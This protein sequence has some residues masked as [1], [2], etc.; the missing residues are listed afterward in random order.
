MSRIVQQRHVRSRPPGL[1]DRPVGQTVATGASDADITVDFFDSC[2]PGIRIEGSVFPTVGGL[3]FFRGGAL[4]P[5][6]ACVPFALISN[7]RSACASP[8]QSSGQYRFRQGS[9]V[10]VLAVRAPRA[11]G[12]LLIFTRLHIRS[13]T[14]RP[15]GDPL[16]SSMSRVV[17][18]GREG[19][20]QRSGTLPT[21]ANL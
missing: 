18:R 3:A 16:P 19:T 7:R 6:N 17:V 13:C 8:K 20:Q 11:T 14:R 4:V 9:S 1:V 10:N 12:E 5:Q 2:L 15:T 21:Y